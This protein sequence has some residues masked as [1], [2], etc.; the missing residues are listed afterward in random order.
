MMILENSSLGSK[1]SENELHPFISGIYIYVYIYNICI[2]YIHI[3]EGIFTI[4]HRSQI[5]WWRR[6]S[7]WH[8]Q[9]MC[10]HYIWK[11]PSWT[12][13]N[14]AHISLATYCIT[15]VFYINV[16]L[17][18]HCCWKLSRPRLC[19]MKYYDMPIPKWA[20]K[21][22]RMAGEHKLGQDAQKWG[23]KWGRE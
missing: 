21:W 10:F 3:V 15:I 6:H 4:E 5:K 8:H 2:I 11:V 7:W 18:F 1:P 20:K 12:H 13:P 23:R 16:L 22:G 17:N 19:K 14:G 9:I